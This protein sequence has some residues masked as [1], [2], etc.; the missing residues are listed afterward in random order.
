MSTPNRLFALTAAAAIALAL[1]SGPALAAKGDCGQPVSNGA[2][3]VATDCLFILQAGVGAQ[4]C[5]PTCICDVNGSGGNPNATDALTCLNVTVGNPSLLNCDCPPVGGV[6]KDK[7]SIGEFIA[8]AGSDLDAGWNGA[9]HNASIVE[10]ASI[11]IQVVRRCGGDG[12]VCQLDADCPGEI[13][14][15]LTCDCDSSTNTECEITGPVGERNCLV[16][17]NKSCNTNADCGAGE[18]ACVKFF[19]PPLPLS[20]EGTPTCVTTYFQQDIS[21]TANSATGEGEASAFLRSRVHLGIQLAKPCPRCGALNQNPQV[22]DNFQCD[23]GPRNGQACSV[24]AISPE[25]G[26]TSKDCPPDATSNVSG[27][28]L[29]INFRSVSTGTRGL[30][31]ELPCGGQLA[32]LHP[33]NGGAV[34]LDTFAPCS[35]NADCLRCTGSPTT[36]CT[37]NADCTGNGT[38]AESPAHPFSCGVYCHCGFCDGNPDAPCF[39]NAECGVGQT[40]RQGTGA[41]QQ[42]KGN[43]CADLACGLGGDERC[44]SPGEPNC[45]NPTPLVGECVDQPFRSCSS[46][47]DCTNAG[48]S[49]PCNRFNRPCFE[50]RIERTGTPSPLGKYCIN[51]PNVGACNTNAD[52]GALGPCVPDSS[53]PTTVALFCIPPTASAS[54]NAAG[55]IPGPGAI[56]FKSAIVSYRC[57]DGRRDGVEQCDDGNNVNGDGCNEI[58]QTE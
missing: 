46:N 24:D 30:D 57:G 7:C 33:S 1:F 20:A 54:I 45:A 55:G 28:G 15:D 34:C 4:T 12:A 48:A 43:N 47:T 17:M 8:L 9:G 13:T 16:A 37:S 21:G 18:G 6:A 44:C 2:L 58:C 39:S 25:F 32:A 49:G 51:N 41:T 50:N 23:G 14:C 42:E 35:T 26:G 56:S 11:F 22:G 52:C 53:E 5:D 27:V 29:A 10:G 36:A 19:G 40:C 38:C 31:A 3:P